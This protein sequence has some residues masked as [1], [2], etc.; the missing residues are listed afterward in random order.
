MST[1]VHCAP[2]TL[3][4]PKKRGP[5]TKLHQGPLPEHLKLLARLCV[6]HDGPGNL[7]YWDRIFEDAEQLSGELFDMINERK[8]KYQT[9]KKSRL[10]FLVDRP[11]RKAFNAYRFHCEQIMERR[12]SPNS[13]AQTK[14]LSVADKKSLP[15]NFDALKDSV[16][17]SLDFPCHFKRFAAAVAKSELGTGGQA[18][19]ECLRRTKPEA[20]AYEMLNLK[21]KHAVVDKSNELV[22]ADVISS[23]QL[24]YKAAIDGAQH[25]QNFMAK[26]NEN[27]GLFNK[28]ERNLPE[29]FKE[30]AFHLARARLYKSSYNNEWVFL[31]RQ[32]MCM[33]LRTLLQ[34]NRKLLVQCQ[35]KEC[36]KSFLSK[37]HPLVNALEQRRMDAATC[38]NCAGIVRID[39]PSQ[40]DDAASALLTLAHSDSSSY[41]S[42]GS[43]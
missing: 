42:E 22:S 3:N 38:G 40:R 34:K 33:A 9:F 18:C 43:S 27:L 6:K 29:I 10:R 12:E 24:E 15:T 13:V 41:T 1:I 23:D 37:I 16:D 19:F 35:N 2:P 20:E 8:A 11:Y 32:P 39:K 30:F 26:H 28:D 31:Q 25:F 4:L 36:F 21:A 5:K 17:A 7:T 14:Q